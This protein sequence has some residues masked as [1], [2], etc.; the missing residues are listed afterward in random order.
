MGQIKWTPSALK[1]L[2]NIE[3]FI[4]QDS[5]YY[6]RKFIERLLSRADALS[7]FPMSGRIVPEFENPAIRELIIGSYRL[8]YRIRRESIR[9]VR[10]HHS[11]QLLTLKSLRKLK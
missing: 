10:V 7:E 9:V 4:S 8:V 11:A 6:A 2:D 1:D 3:A 5:Q